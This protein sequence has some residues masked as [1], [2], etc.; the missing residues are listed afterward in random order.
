MGRGAS[1]ISGSN[2]L[3]PIAI[4]P[5]WAYQPDENTDLNDVVKNPIPFVGDGEDWRIGNLLENETIQTSYDG[6]ADVDV[7]K[8]QTLQPFVLKSGITNYQ[9]FDGSEKPYV[10]ELDGKY[11]LLDGNH[12]V[13][14]AKLDGKK[15]VNV[16]LSKRRQR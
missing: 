16:I 7:D 8:I 6:N 15:T 9:S 12:R 14:K 4:N 2:A 13:A 11:Y 3:Q 10:C 1:G 5:D